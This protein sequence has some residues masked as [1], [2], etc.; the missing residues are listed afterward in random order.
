MKYST[1]LEVLT[2]KPQTDPGIAEEL[3]T[4]LS[5]SVVLPSDDSYEEA[6][7]VWNRAVR[8][9]PAMIAFCESTTDVQRAVR[10]ARRHGLPLSVRGGGHDWAGRALK[11]L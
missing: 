8:Y 5:G 4:A 6:R 10:V 7:R 3:Q 9:R 1:K 11:G 2:S